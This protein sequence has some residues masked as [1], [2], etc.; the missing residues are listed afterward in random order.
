MLSKTDQK[1]EEKRVLRRFKQFQENHDTKI[2]FLKYY[3]IIE[4]QTYS[5]ILFAELCVP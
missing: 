3:F 5:N 1:F 2:I 4:W